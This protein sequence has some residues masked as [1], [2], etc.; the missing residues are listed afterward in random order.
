MLKNTFIHLPG[1]GTKKER[2]FWEKG[3]LTWD[4]LDRSFSRQPNLFP[5]E[6]DSAVG[7]MLEESRAA[8]ARR[9]FDFFAER[10]PNSE[11]YR[12]A[13]T[14]PQSTVFL[15]IESTGLSLYY[16]HITLIGASD[17][18][19]YFLYTRSHDLDAIVAA[20]SKAK[21]LVTFNGTSFD[22]KFLRQEF[23]QLNFPRAHIDLRFCGLPYGLR[24]TQK[25]IEQELGLL[26]PDEIRTVRG[27]RAPILWYRYTR[28]DMD[29]GR[30]LIEYNHSDI[31]GMKF[32]LDVILERI[33]LADELLPRFARRPEFFR[34]HRRLNWS[35]EPIEPSS[36]HIFLPAFEGKIGPQVAY[37]DLAY[38]ARTKNLRIVGIDLTG[39][40]QRPTGWSSLVGGEAATKLIRS[41]QDLI[42]ETLAVKPDIVS[43]DSPLSLPK[44]RLRVTNDD[45]GRKKFGIMRECERTLKKRGVNVYP[46]LIDSMQKLTA[47]GIRLARHLRV[48]GIPVIESYPGA[49]QDIMGIP[50]KR[51]SLDFLKEGL[52]E[53]GIS[54]D[55]LSAK[56]RHDEVDA[57]TSAVVGLFF[58]S[59]KFE[60]LGNDEEEYLIIP[61]LLIPPG[62]WRSRL[63]VGISG[64]I[65]AGKTTAAQ[66][67][68]RTGFAYTRYSEVLADMLKAKGKVVNRSTLQKLGEDIHRKPGQRWLSRQLVKRLP[69]TGN[70][71]IDGLRFPEDHAFLTEYFGPAFCHVHVSAPEN[72]RKRRY[73]GNGLPATEFETAIR[74]RVES[75]IPLLGNSAHSH[76]INDKSLAEF[77][78]EI[79]RVVHTK[80]EAK[81]LEKA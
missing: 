66:V 80:Q 35:L 64:T 77:E 27:E 81:L 44:G 21:C 50:R 57:V 30:K 55:F 22:L 58:W 54:G 34:G 11:H 41:D 32:I 29:A 16:D 61:D 78:S 72:V 25:N 56:V 42:Q 19:R 10:L 45:P 7:R 18:D 71:V 73:I 26:R 24:G 63:V 40:E 36:N 75:K 60:G 68:A 76:L 65:A 38:D 5:T 14:E 23:P 46:C 67:L 12:I 3:I 20:L 33:F 13:L 1:I 17:L 53:F 2:A 6:S 49:A 39:S 8:L 79:I 70:V 69:L 52:G 62:P 9:D 15:D 51:A 74:E 43:I 28:G 59:G 48:L 31:E 37:S 47:R 4:D